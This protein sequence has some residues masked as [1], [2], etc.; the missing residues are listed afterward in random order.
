V[1]SPERVAEAQAA[2]DRLIGLPL[3]GFNGYLSCRYFEFGEQHVTTSRRGVEYLKADW[4][5][6]LTCNWR[7]EWGNGMSVSRDLFEPDWPQDNPIVEQFYSE[8]D[9]HTHIL[10]SINV[11]PDASLHLKLTDGFDLIVHPSAEEVHSL[12]CWFLMPRVTEIPALWLG[13]G[14]LSWVGYYRPR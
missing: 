2:F 8:V 7:V 10:Q 5:L 1:L 14:E 9:G 13:E 4:S 3:V 11:F 6:R 12:D